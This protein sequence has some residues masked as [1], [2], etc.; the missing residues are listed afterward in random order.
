[1]KFRR[2]ADA[3]FKRSS[4]ATIVVATP[5]TT[6]SGLP[7]LIVST[8]CA[9]HGTPTFFWIRS[10]NCPAVKGSIAGQTKGRKASNPHV[11]PSEPPSREPVSQSEPPLTGMITVPS[12]KRS[13]P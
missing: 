1:M 10:I 9:R 11:P 7:A 4:V 12:S 8:V 2:A 6:V 3:R 5:F 13:V